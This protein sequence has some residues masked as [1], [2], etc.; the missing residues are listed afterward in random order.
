MRRNVCPESGIPVFKE[1]PSYQDVCNGVGANIRVA[2]LQNE[3][4]TEKCLIRYENGLK[5][6]KDDPK[7]NAE[8]VRKLFSPS[9]PLE[10]F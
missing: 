9:S 4:A 5:N 3:T 1:A 10:K 2:R 7:N 8:R 6:A